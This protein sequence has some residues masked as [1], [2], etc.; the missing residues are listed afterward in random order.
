[1]GSHRGRARGG[2]E[3]ERHSVHDR[4]RRGRVLRSEDR[5]PHGGRPQSQVADGDDPARFADAFALWLDLCRPGQPRASATSS[6]ERST[7]PSN[8]S[9]A[10]SSSTRGRVSRSGSHRPDPPDPRRP[11]SPR[12]VHALRRNWKV[13]GSTS[14]SGT[15][16]S[17]SGSATRR[18]R[19]SLRRRLR[20]T[21]VGCDSLAVRKRGGE[22]I[23]PPPWTPCVPRFLRLLLFR[24]ESR[25]AHVLTS[26]A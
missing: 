12:G 2:A 5:P 9:S 10:S 22:Q 8:A 6:T 26:R 23:Y 16:R 18:S 4:G 7:G 1:M 17:E 11:G 13:C 21:R 3:A 14:T 25:S 15:R 19:R 20:R 24:P